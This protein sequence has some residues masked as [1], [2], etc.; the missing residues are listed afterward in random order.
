MDTYSF[1][2]YITAND[3]YKDISQ[4]AEIRFDT[5]NYE[6]DDLEEKK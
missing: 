5:A 1:I 3:I 6:L 2:V 4:D